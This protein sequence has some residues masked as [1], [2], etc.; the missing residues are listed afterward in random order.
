[1]TKRHYQDP[2]LS[3]PLPS[4]AVPWLVILVLIACIWLG[5]KY[6]FGAPAQLLGGPPPRNEY[7]QYLQQPKATPGSPRVATPAATRPLPPATDATAP[8]A[9]RSV[10][11]PS[12]A[13]TPRTAQ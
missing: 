9:G 13:P 1:M 10:V 2:I 7:V 12:A 4:T 3:K 6:F 11:H 8:A 5:H